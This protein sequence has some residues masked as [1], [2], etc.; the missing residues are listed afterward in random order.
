MSQISDKDM[1]E[2]TL[3]LVSRR[4]LKISGVRQILNF[5]ESNVA[6]ITACGE[7][8]VDGFSLNID[9]LDL[10]K[11]TASIVGDIVGINYVNDQPAKKRRFRLG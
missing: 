8:A 2:H 3:A 7:M 10:D 4:E 9:A 1:Q 11:G 5:D 6:F